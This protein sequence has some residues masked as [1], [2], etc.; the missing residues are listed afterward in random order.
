[1]RTLSDYPLKAPH[2]GYL[3]L[4]I[5]WRLFCLIKTR[6][7]LSALHCS[8]S[9]GQEPF[10][11]FKQPDNE[12]LIPTRFNMR[13]QLTTARRA[14]QYL[15]QN[16]PPC[17]ISTSRSPTKLIHSILPPYRAT[18]VNLSETGQT[19]QTHTK[20]IPKNLQSRCARHIPQLH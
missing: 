13:K 10:L 6:L 3:K 20:Y 11:G 16:R 14:K 9:A 8:Q 18:F 1:M 19:K 15:N 12:R 2:A 7:S 5:N 4:R 17:T